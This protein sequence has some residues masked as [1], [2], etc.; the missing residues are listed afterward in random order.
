MIRAAPF[1]AVATAF[2]AL[3]GCQREAASPDPEGASAAPSG[4]GSEDPETKPGLAL[5]DGRLVL[6]AVK[7]NPGA[8]YFTLSNG[9]AKPVTFAAIEITGAGMAMLHQTMASGGHSTMAE[10]AD[11]VVAPG[12]KLVLAP[13]GKHVMVFDLPEDLKP[14]ASVEATLTFAD[15]DKL[16][17]PLA[18]VAPGGAN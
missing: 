7:G 1:L 8:A 13:S 6:P 16:S 11:P 4:A 10:M 2:L 17:A 9:S 3:A 12:E 14:G 15:G 5:A 18:V